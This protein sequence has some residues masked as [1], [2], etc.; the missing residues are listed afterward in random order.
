VCPFGTWSGGGLQMMRSTHAPTLSTDGNLL[1][2]C[3]AV[4][5][6]YYAH[7]N[8]AGA[9]EQL[10]CPRGFF[11][12]G[13]THAPERCEHDF[14]CPPGSAAPWS[15]RW[16]PCDAGSLNIVGLWP[17]SSDPAS[18]FAAS[19]FS[20]QLTNPAW[21]R[22]LTQDDA[23]L[24]AREYRYRQCSDTCVSALAALAWRDNTQLWKPS[25]LGIW[26]ALD[27]YGLGGGFV[28]PPMA[29]SSYTGKP[30]WNCVL[31]PPNFYCPNNTV[32]PIPVSATR[33]CPAR[34][35]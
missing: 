31:C 18:T 24:G 7:A 13:G 11:C 23:I 33:P 14:W 2:L 32:A 35:V 12:R 15:P 19:F 28:Y 22:Q 9:S 10:E 26:H 3:V 27:F 34:S 16:P 5:P 21:T 20:V 30:A 8:V 29:T 1:T 25:S 6:G 17:H 4:L